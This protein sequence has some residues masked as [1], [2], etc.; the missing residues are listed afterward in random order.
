MVRSL[1]LCSR[2][3]NTVEKQPAPREKS[4]PGGEILPA[5]SFRK[6][7]LRLVSADKHLAYRRRMGRP[8]RSG[9]Q[10][11]HSTTKARRKPAKRMPFASGADN[12]NL[13]IH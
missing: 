9:R 10:V 6:T 12:T 5:P 7:R 2:R 4:A 8:A 13:I 11:A 1:K 3:S